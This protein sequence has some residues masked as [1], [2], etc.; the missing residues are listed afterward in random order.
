MP[1]AGESSLLFAASSW[2]VGSGVIPELNVILGG[3]WR[4]LSGTDS[5]GGG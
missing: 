5:G 2:T 1:S 3:W 4:P